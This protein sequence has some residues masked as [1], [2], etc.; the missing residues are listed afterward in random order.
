MRETVL[1]GK[2]EDQI[3]LEV[4]G[5]DSTKGT[6]CSWFITFASHFMVLRKVS[7]SI[8]DVSRA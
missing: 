8:P 3:A 7:G 1:Y 2:G 4:G 6:W 5:L